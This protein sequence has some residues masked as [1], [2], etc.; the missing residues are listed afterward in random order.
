MTPLSDNLYRIFFKFVNFPFCL[1]FKYSKQNFSL[2]HILN[3]LKPL[4]F[5]QV[6]PSKSQNNFKVTPKD[7]EYNS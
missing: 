6:I 3:I 7:L 1:E 5:L 2:L 4:V